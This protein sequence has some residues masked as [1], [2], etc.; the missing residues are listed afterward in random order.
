MDTVDNALGPGQILFEVCWRADEGGIR[1]RMASHGLSNGK[2]VALRVKLW[3]K[4]QLSENNIFTGAWIHK[5]SQKKQS[6]DFLCGDAPPENTEYIYSRNMLLNKGGIAC[7]RL[8]PIFSRKYSTAHAA[9]LLNHLM[10]DG[11]YILSDGKENRRSLFAWVQTSHGSCQV[12][13]WWALQGV[14]HNCGG[15]QIEQNRGKWQRLKWSKKTQ[16]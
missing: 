2:V 3:I 10:V 9:Q 4:H 8:T 1:G 13:S 15:W 11:E 5:H 14:S 12:L 7:Y 6:L 16:Q